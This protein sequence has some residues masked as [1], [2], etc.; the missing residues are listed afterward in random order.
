MAR[1]PE[2][3]REELGPEGQAAYDAIAGS[4][5][6]VRGP[7]AMLLHHP[8][9]G[10][11]IG[12]VGEILRFHSRLSGADRELAILAGGR[13]V[14]AVYE[15]AA[16]EPIA[17]KEGTRPEAIEVLRNQSPTTGLTPREALIIDTVRALYRQHRL[18]DEHFARLE[19][20]FDRATLVELIV[21]PA[22]YGM[23]GFALNAFE[24]ELPPGT[25]PA[26]PR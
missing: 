2:V 1:L 13:E 14:E 12:A 9:L 15:W 24:V 8:E 16:H 19:A 3:K 20:E 7:F 18:S 22:Y 10:E 21:L 17:L 5:G 26:F 4:R 6:S 11:R 23:I 25:T